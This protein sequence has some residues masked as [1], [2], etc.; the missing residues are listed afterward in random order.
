MTG[1][2][3]AVNGVE[4]CIRA[5]KGVILAAGGFPHS[6]E[7]RKKLMPDG[8]VSQHSVAVEEDQGDSLTAAVPLGAAVGTEHD[9]PSFMTPQSIMRNADG[10][11]DTWLHSWDRAKPGQIAVNAMGQRFAN[12]AQSYHK[13]CQIMIREN[14][15]QQ[16][17][18]AYLVCDAAHLKRWGFG[19]IRHGTRNLQPYIDNG[20]L[21]A[22]NS[23]AELARAIRLDPTV[24][25]STVSKFNDACLTGF[26][27]DFQRGESPID[28]INGDPTNKPNPCMGPLQV[29]PFYAMAI[30]P[31]NIGTSIGLKA[32][33][34]AQ[35]LDQSDRPIPGLYA[36]GNDMSSVMCG[37]Y[38]GPGITLGPGVVFAYRAARHATRSIS[39]T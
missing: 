15:R 18:P 5:R 20:Y 35:V 1:A 3:V 34:D 26:D 19:L 37:H 22:G 39:A 38:P 21:K 31:G 8:Y 9:A 2:V 10:S 27:V 12:E 11:T 29:A 24:L 7:W 6:S 28:K 25:G 17:V 14:E 33:T 4:T 13:F 23:I 36:C 32:N 30:W 16:T